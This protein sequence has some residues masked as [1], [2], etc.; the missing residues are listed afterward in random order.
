MNFS[1][2]RQRLN[3]RHCDQPED[4]VFAP[5]FNTLI[6]LYEVHSRLSAEQTMVP[7]NKKLI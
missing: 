5:E 2:K 6:T 3:R 1:E 4:R 7:E